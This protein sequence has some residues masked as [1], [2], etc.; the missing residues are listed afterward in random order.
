LSVEDNGVGI[1]E[2]SVESNGMGLRSMRYRA[3]VLNGSLEI[4]RLPEGGT[5]VR[6]RAPLVTGGRLYAN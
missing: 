6:C 5:R 4:S 2:E 3:S 1:G